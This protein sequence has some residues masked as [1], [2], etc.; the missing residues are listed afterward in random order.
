MRQGPR[1]PWPNFAQDLTMQHADKTPKPHSDNT[2]QRLA[3]TTP[4]PS[5]AADGLHGSPRMVTQRRQLHSLF[6]TAA[7]LQEDSTK[8]APAQRQAAPEEELLQGRFDTAQ[9]QAGEEDDALQMKGLPAAPAQHAGAAAVQLQ[10]AP[11]EEEAPAQLQ[12]GPEE[13]LLQGRFDTTVQRQAG[14][15]EEPLQ[16]KGQAR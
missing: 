10:A 13:E 14:E 15:D 7:Q 6:G 1:P 4:A 5:S 9:R 2:A 3:K 16:T 12:A 8:E 11:M